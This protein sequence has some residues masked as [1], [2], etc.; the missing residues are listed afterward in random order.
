MNDGA[1]AVYPNSYPAEMA[2][3]GGVEWSSS[4]KHEQQQHPFAEERAQRDVEVRVGVLPVR[5]R[6]RDREEQHAP[7]HRRRRRPPSSPSASS[8]SSSY[9]PGVKGHAT[10]AAAAAHRVDDALLRGGVL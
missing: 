4:A 7:V 1:F 3:F 2:P 8:S 6:R 5:V 9:R 10:R